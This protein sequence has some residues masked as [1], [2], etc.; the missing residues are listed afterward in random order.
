MA[1][2]SNEDGAALEGDPAPTLGEQ[3]Y[4]DLKALILMGELRPGE[5]LAEAD[6]AQ[7]LGVSR[8]PLRHALSRLS[9][10]KLIT[11]R[12]QGGYLV[13]R[14]DA[15][16]IA[17]LV[18]L[19]EA[20]DTHAARLA[21]EVA[22]AADLDRLRACIGQL[23]SVAEHADAK[24]IAAEYDLGLRI[25]IIIAEAAGNQALLDAVKQVYERLQLAIWLEVSWADHLID[26]LGEHRAIVEAICARDPERAADAARSHVRRSLQNMLRV[27]EMRERR[28]TGVP[29]RRAAR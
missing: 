15:A 4:E 26:R 19:R 22:S 9:Q 13:V 10:E 8:T 24:E 20:L 21:A 16:A 12:A 25:H 11:K 23:E 6:M 14:L 18:G 5:R 1:D 2:P 27:L 17:D 3:T 7:R 28:A 29:G